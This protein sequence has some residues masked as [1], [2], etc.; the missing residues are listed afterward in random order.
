MGQNLAS[1]LLTSALLLTSPTPSP[2]PVNHTIDIGWQKLQPKTY[3]VQPGDSLGSIAQKIYGDPQY[4]TVLW[5]DNQWITD[6]NTLYSDWH[7]TLHEATPSAQATVLPQALQ[8]KLSR[9]PQPSIT[10]QVT[11]TPIPTTPQS[12][13]TASASAIPASPTVAASATPT[14][15]PTSSPQASEN[16]PIKTPFDDVYKA[17]GAKYGIPWQILYGIHLTESGLR[18]NSDVTNHQGT[19]ATGPMQFMPGTWR[20]YAV[21]GDGDGKADITNVTDAIYTAANFIQKHGSV[22]NAL[23]A[24]GGNTQGTMRAA[25]ARGLDPSIVQ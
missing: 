2:A 10:P 4:W 24:Y 14:A 15:V 25:L 22:R 17:A 13:V 23:R 11:A 8:D 19:G 16:D 9:S 1:T 5:Q 6:P 20:A 18:G 7:L 3:T 12:S 21:D